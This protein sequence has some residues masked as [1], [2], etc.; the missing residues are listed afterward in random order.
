MI[1][2]RGTHFLRDLTTCGFIF[3]CNRHEEPENIHSSFFVCSFMHHSYLGPHVMF[4]PGTLTK[5]SRPGDR[6]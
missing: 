6:R 3:H 5:R 4:F 1:R 2:F